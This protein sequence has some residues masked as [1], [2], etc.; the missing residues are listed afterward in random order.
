M[1]QPTFRRHRSRSTRAR[2]AAAA[3]LAVVA[4][5]A[6]TTAWLLLGRDDGPSASDAAKGYAGAWSAG[7]DGQAAG[8]TDRPRTAA[9]ALAASRRGLDGAKVAATVGAVEEEGDAAMAPVDVAWEVPRV[10]RFA[11]RTQLRLAR[12]NDRW[13]VRW[14]P[15]AVHPKLTAETRL[16]TAVESRPRG[17]I[18]ARDGRAIVRPRGVVDV[19]VEVRRVKD[20][21]ATAQGLAALDGIDVQPQELAQRIREAPRGR[22]LPVI[23][24]RGDA[25]ERIAEQLRDVPGASVNPRAAP[26]APTKTFG[27]A[28]LGTVGPVTAEQLRKDPD[29][30]PGDEIGQSGLQDAYERRLAATA[31]RRVVMRDVASGIAEETLLERPGRRGRALR[32]TLDLDVQAAAETA[33][34]DRDGNAALAVVQ[35]STGDVLAIANRPADSAYDRALAGLYPPGSTFKVVSTAALLRAGLDPDRTVDCP[36]TLTV[37][38]KPFRNFEGNA[39]GAV[40]FRRDFAESCN[41]A[42]VSLAGE[43]GDRALTDAARDF[44]LGLEL[45]A[46]LPAAEAS[47]PP[48]TSA[49]GKAAMMIGQDR[50][51]ASPLAMAGV[52]ATVAAGRWHAPRLV[53][54]APETAGPRLAADERDTLRS[55]MRDV[56][57]SGTGTALAGL[58]GEVL[59]KSGTAE[60]GGGDPPPTH[61]WFIAARDDLAL[62][63][64]V[65]GGKAGGSVAAPIAARF[66][67]ALDSR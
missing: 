22:F 39:A 42:F 23:T 50:I 41:T 36:R 38:G 63:V 31:T 32:T 12:S 56:V 18:L 2:R 7:R 15:R 13:V 40:P 5:L 54:D 47:V 19:A 3:A 57:S 34:G 59:G 58:P 35:P 60:Y 10:G 67:A 27:R 8:L 44:G 53:A 48:P 33:L 11:Y 16:G 55:L 28:V 46:G 30:A 29:L 45:D 65:E 62:A 66:F 61:A 17:R 49:V 37:E 14:S 1:P 4:A 26:L 20:A 25:Y 6:G 51:V 43:L 52:A 24:L 21:D 9:A 64:L